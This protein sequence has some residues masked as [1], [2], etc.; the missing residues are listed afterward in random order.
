[1]PARTAVGARHRPPSFSSSNS[2]SKKKDSH[3][4]VLYFLLACLSAALLLV[5]VFVFASKRSLSAASS[6]PPFSAVELRQW[7]DSLDERDRLISRLADEA[8]LDNAKLSKLTGG[9]HWD[10][11]AEEDAVRSPLRQPGSSARRQPPAAPRLS[12]E[13]SL[14][15]SNEVPET[16]TG[17][18]GLS[19]LTSPFQT[20]CFEHFV[21]G[22]PRCY[23][24][25]LLVVPTKMSAVG[26]DKVVDTAKE[27]ELVYSLKMSPG[28]FRTT[29][30][31]QLP[32]RTLRQGW[33]INKAFLATARAS[34]K[35]V[36]NCDDNITLFIARYHASNLFHALTDIWNVYHTLPASLWHRSSTTLKL[37]FLD[38]NPRDALDDLWGAVIPLSSRPAGILETRDKFCAGRAI[39]VTPGYLSPLW[40]HDKSWK[41]P[42]CPAEAENFVD[43]VLQSFGLLDSHRAGTGRVLIIDNPSPTSLRVGQGSWFGALQSSYSNSPFASSRQPVDLRLI[44]AALKTAG[45]LVDLV[46]L[47]SLPFSEQLAR[48]RSADFVL[49]FAGEPLLAHALLMSKGSTLLELNVGK[50][51]VI[52]RL[53]NWRNGVSYKRILVPHEGVA[54]TQTELDAIVQIYEQ[55]MRE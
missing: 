30:T 7:R 4:S 37:Y 6:E 24:S 8:A 14:A 27:P 11:G 21:T 51:G 50:D 17:D 25:D 42:P 46:D 5:V 53:A 52:E 34:S 12:S 40:E 16:V 38:S 19:K 55:K 26:K 44:E 54:V 43:H 45:A 35:D 39:F 1:M 15:W 23:L 48:V 29:H 9:S 2:K 33:Y 20:G 49:G 31:D 36:A 22:A 3:N 28:A 32:R 18:Y 10:K 47:G 41:A 13:C